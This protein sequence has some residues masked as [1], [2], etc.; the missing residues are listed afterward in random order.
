MLAPATERTAPPRWVLEQAAGEA[1]ARLRSGTA[2]AH[3]PEWDLCADDA[4]HFVNAHV[5]IDE[6]QIDIG[7]TIAFKLWPEQA[8]ALA[9]MAVHR[10]VIILKSRQ[11][12]MTWLVL[13]YIL[14]LCLFRPGRVALLFSKKERDAHELVRRIRVMYYRLPG[15]L[16]ARVPLLKPNTG[17]LEWANGSRVESHA[18]TKGAGRTYT[19]SI[20]FCDEFA[21][22]EWGDEVYTALKP[23]VD[24]G[25]QLILNSTANGESG[26]FAEIWRKAVAHVNNFWAIFLAWQADP[27]R[28]PEW[29]KA[30]AEDAISTATDL[31]EYPNTPEDA[32]QNTGSESFLP[33]MTLWDILKAPGDHFP[34]ALPSLAPH[35]PMI[36][37]ADAATGRQDGKSDCFGLLGITAHPTRDGLLAVRYAQKWQAAKGQHIDFDGTD[38]W[39]GPLREVRRLHTDYSVFQFCYDPKELAYAASLLVAEGLYCSPFNQQG[40]RLIG[41]RLLFDLI[42]QKR[43]V[44]DGN[45]DLREH[46]ANAD[47]QVNSEDRTLRIVKRTE[48][49]K[50]DLAICAA[51]AAKR[52]RDLWPE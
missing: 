5:V 13:A 28:T 48:G 33:S 22:L 4:A 47:R 14:W 41:D 10:L 27:R 23:T 52:H 42:A 29:R 46:I 20:A 40:E 51:M 2:D 19:A 37:A 6:P 43:L 36:L 35:E 11:I 32:F 24:G 9:E 15:W 3:S 12:G 31:Q 45:A 1:M 49:N 44:H 26:L 17:E 16:Q 30:V 18:A 50:I 34:E 8:R 25:G 21:F 39:P 38:D 7:S